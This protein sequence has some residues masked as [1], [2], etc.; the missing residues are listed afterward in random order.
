MNRL[1]CMKSSRPSRL[2]RSVRIQWLPGGVGLVAQ[3]EVRQRLARVLKAQSHLHHGDEP[4]VF[5][6]SKRRTILQHEFRV[7]TDLSRSDDRRLGKGALEAGDLGLV[8]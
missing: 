6:G 3:R 5:L 1:D 4:P 2:V 8:G 7:T